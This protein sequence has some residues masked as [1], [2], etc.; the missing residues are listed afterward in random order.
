M[1]NRRRQIFGLL[2][3]FLAVEMAC[4]DMV[5]VS[6][7]NS[8][9]KPLRHVSDGKE[10]QN[11]TPFDRYDLLL[12]DHFDLGTIQFLPK[13]PP[14][15]SHPSEA[16]YVIEL[17]DGSDSC[18]LCLYA[19]ISLGLCSA[20]HWIRRLSLGHI[21]E[22]YH[23]G[24][25]FQIGHRFAVSPESLC[26]VPAHCFVQPDNTTKDS[27]THFYRAIAFPLWRKPQ[28]TSN[29]LASRGPPS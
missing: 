11:T 21:P 3:V 2:V 16:S 22:W 20:P 17:T 26:P 19:L 6:K 7:L 8:E 27:L 14:D 25:P 24:G 9:R 28:F 29:A 4:A 13:T 18:S 23:D 12:L 10:I 1:N 15:F 5:S